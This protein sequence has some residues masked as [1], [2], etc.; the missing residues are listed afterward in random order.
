MP[1]EEVPGAATGVRALLSLFSMSMRSCCWCWRPATGPAWAFVLGEGCSAEVDVRLPEG[2]V[3]GTFVPLPPSL[4]L[5]FDAEPEA[6]RSC[7]SWIM[8]IAAFSCKGT[9]REGEEGGQNG[10]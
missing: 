1:D 6:C 8:W 3:A 7:S 5:A 10:V 9:R 2:E 4:L